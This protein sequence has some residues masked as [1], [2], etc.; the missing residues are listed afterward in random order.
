MIGCNYLKRNGVIMISSINGNYAGYSNPSYGNTTRSD[1]SNS[2]DSNSSTDELKAKD[3]VQAEEKQSIVNQLPQ[4][5][6]VNTVA[7]NEEILDK[8]DIPKG[9]EI[10]QSDDITSLISMI[11]TSRNIVQSDSGEA[12]F[13]MLP[14]LPET[15]EQLILTDSDSLNPKKEELYTELVQNFN[16]VDTNKD[17][18]VSYDE[19]LNFINRS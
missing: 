15:E 16:Q 18:L 2:V 5:L 9:R 19:A 4:Q 6:Q 3:E 17:E 11:E 7:K 8:E 14:E 10:S 12:L 1:S 13:Q